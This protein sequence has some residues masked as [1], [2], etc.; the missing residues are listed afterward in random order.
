MSENVVGVI[1]LTAFLL[2]VGGLWLWS[3]LRLAQAKKLWPKTWV[4]EGLAPP[5][6]I[7]KA[8][9]IIAKYTPG[10]PQAGTVIWVKD[11]FSVG[12]TMAAGTVDSY[13]PIVIR[14]M[15]FDKPEKTAL[16]HELGHVW[17]ELTKQGFG[18][19]PTDTRFVEW[20]SK[21]N[22][23]IAVALSTGVAV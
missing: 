11:P 5:P 8:L 23:E 13:E 14:L 9:E 17:S 21:I 16:T 12:W 3:R 2:L 22:A 1:V 19:A 4:H 18:E 10:M 7:D 6:G 15:W 20:I